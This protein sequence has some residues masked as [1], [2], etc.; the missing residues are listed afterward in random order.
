VRFNAG[1]ISP[2]QSFGTKGVLTID[3][4]G[5]RDSAEAVVQQPDGKLIVGGFARVGNRLVFALVRLLP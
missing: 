1:K 5:D 3:F 2:D 4:F